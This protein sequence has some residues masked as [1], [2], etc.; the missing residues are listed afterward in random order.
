MLTWVIP[1]SPIIQEA[2]RWVFL[3]ESQ[4]SMTAYRLGASP[5]PEELLRE[6]LP[7]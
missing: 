7:H 6:L 3:L 2:V 5:L 4:G 1:A